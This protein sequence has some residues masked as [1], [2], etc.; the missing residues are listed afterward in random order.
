MPEIIYGDDI[1]PRTQVGQNI[2]LTWMCTV[3]VSYKLSIFNTVSSMFLWTMPV[4]HLCQYFNMTDIP[5]PVY[6]TIILDCTVRYKQ[7]LC[8]LLSGYS[9]LIW[10]C[11]SSFCYALIKRK[12]WLIDQP[13]R[14]ETASSTS[15]LGPCALHHYHSYQS[16]PTLNLQHSSIKQQWTGWSRKK[17]YMKNSRYITRSTSQWQNDSSRL[18]WQTPSKGIWSAT[19]LVL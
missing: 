6:I 8:N 3:A 17:H 4:Q 19:S 9:C 18:W 15:L 10:A 2:C 13:C 11:S 7:H 12:Y 16:L 14:H 5:M 1:C